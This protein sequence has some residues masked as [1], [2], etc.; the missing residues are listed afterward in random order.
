[1]FFFDN[2]RPVILWK[3][4]IKNLLELFFYF[5]SNH[6]NLDKN[7]NKSFKLRYVDQTDFHPHL[8]YLPKLTKIFKHFLFNHNY[9][10]KLK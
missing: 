10:G 1:M 4:D 7:N 3:N 8:N 6:L 9:N 5:Y 2:M